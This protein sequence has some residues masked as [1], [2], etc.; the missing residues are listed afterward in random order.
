MKKLFLCLLIAIVAFT[1]FADSNKFRVGATVE[2]NEYHKNKEGKNVRYCHVSALC[3]YELDEDWTVY[4]QAGTNLAGL[5]QIAYGPI[6]GKEPTDEFALGCEHSF[7]DSIFKV[8]AVAKA[9]IGYTDYRALGLTLSASK[10]ISDTTLGFV[11]ACIGYQTL[12]TKFDSEKQTGNRFLQIGC[13][14]TY[15]L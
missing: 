13:G 5:K 15:S 8:G 9:F 1:V 14:I 10:N 3:T 11:K 6:K 2:T 7:S 4:L 12:D